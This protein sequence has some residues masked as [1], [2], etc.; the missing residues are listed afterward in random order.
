MQKINVEI[1]FI[2]KTAEEWKEFESEE[3]YKAILSNL[4]TNSIE[5][6]KLLLTLSVGLLGF[7]ISL[8]INM[9]YN[10]KGTE[11]TVSDILQI[12]AFLF[13]SFTVLFSSLAIYVLVK[14][15]E[16]DAK[17]LA[18]RIK[19]DFNDDD[20]IEEKKLRNDLDIYDK[21]AKDYFIAGICM[22][23]LFIISILAKNIFLGIANG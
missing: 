1:D 20:L 15:F 8:L 13:G 5:F 9:N 4:Y 22:I 3:K 7:T 17:Y 11:Y 2:P 21:K 14:V 18:I 19:D 10:H 16:I 12:F 6:D 23:A